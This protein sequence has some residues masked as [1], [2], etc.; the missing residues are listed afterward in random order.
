MF[1][2]P[3]ENGRPV[4]AG[5][6]GCG[7]F[8][9]SLLARAHSVPGFALPVL[10]DR[11]PER[12]ARLLDRS[13]PELDLAVAG[14]AAQAAAAFEAGRTVLLGDPEPMMTLPIDI[15]VEATGDPE[16]AA[17]NG[18]RALVADRHLAIV[19]N[20][21]E[22]LLGP[23]LHEKAE[24]Q[25][26][27]HTVVDGVQPGLL[28]RLITW[29]R[30]L[31]LEVVAAG[32]ASAHDFVLDSRRGTVTADLRTVSAPRLE[33]LW[34]YDDP[35]TLRARAEVLID[36][37]R[38]PVADFCELSV[39]ANTVSLGVDLP[40]LHA[41][42]LRTIEIPDVIRPA[43][44]GGLLDREG[45]VD[46]FTGLRRPEEASFAGGVF[47]IVR[48]EHPPTWDLLRAK[49]HIVSQ[50]GRYAMIYHPQHL[51]GVEAPATLLRAVR[52]GLP[53]PGTNP[54]PTVDLVGRANRALPV[55]TVFEIGERQTIDGLEPGLI[56]ATTIAVDRPLPY[57]LLPGS[58]LIRPLAPGHLPTAAHVT[59]PPGSVRW[60]LRAEQDATFI[61]RPSSDDLMD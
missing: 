53:T 57:Y 9:Q 45:V 35:G 42:I 58:T 32:K 29:A 33:D 1:L 6:I 39:V 44:D 40:E 2:E 18:E 61:G 25:G 31:G 14:S 43:A 7:E 23:I 4:R 30:A 13:F 16:A 38:R 36:L 27:V 47:V 3:I 60:R 26:L 37:P 49:G 34:R 54:H 15:V 5:L 11:D 50:D 28:I 55:G 59:P 12:V 56:E 17:A 10:C 46:V 22:S 20:E 52:L 21:A 48:C 41:P 8:G 24:A 51:L 19:T